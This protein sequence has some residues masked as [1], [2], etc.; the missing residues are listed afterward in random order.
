MLKIL[1][2]FFFF[3]ETDLNNVCQNFYFQNN[4]QCAFE[5]QGM[6]CVLF[7]RIWQLY[8][9]AFFPLYYNC[10]IESK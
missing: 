2:S 5:V 7:P 3:A 9:F 8:I 10:V 1:Q 6:K 4:I